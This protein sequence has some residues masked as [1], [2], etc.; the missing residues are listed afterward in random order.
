MNNKIQPRYCI[1]RIQQYESSRYTT[2]EILDCDFYIHDI[3]EG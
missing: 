3:I 1:I 2:I